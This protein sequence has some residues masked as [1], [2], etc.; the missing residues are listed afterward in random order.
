M[1]LFVMATKENKM[2][3]VRENFKVLAKVSQVSDV[4]LGPLA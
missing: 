4:T 2:H 3:T 1:K